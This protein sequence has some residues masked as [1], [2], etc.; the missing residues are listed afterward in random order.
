MSFWMRVDGPQSQR[1]GFDSRGS[2]GTFDW[3]RRIIALDV[4]PP[5]VLIHFGLILEGGGQTWINDVTLEFLDRRIGTTYQL[6]QPGQPFEGPEFVRDLYMRS[7][8]HPLNLDFE[9]R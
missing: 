4:R 6:H 2:S 8:L 5:A 1:L 7:P 3:D 9:Q